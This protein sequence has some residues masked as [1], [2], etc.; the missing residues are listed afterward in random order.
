MSIGFYRLLFFLRYNFRC[1]IVVGVGIVLMEHRTKFIDFNCDLAQVS[2]I[3]EED[4]GLGLIDY[5]SSVN[6]ACGFHS[7]NPLAISNAIQHCRFKNKVVGAHIG[8]PDTISDVAS[9]SEDAI[10]AIVL[11][12]LGALDSFA[13]ANSLNIEHV[14]PHGYMYQLMSENLEFTTSVAKAI[15]KFNKWLLLYGPAGDVLEKAGAEAKLN[16]AREVVLNMPYNS[17]G[18]INF[19][20]TPI[21]DNELLISKLKRLIYHS[22]VEVEQGQFVKINFDTIHF[23]TNENVIDFLK[24]ASQIVSPR[25][26]NF[27]NAAAS[28]WVE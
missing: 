16:V 4:K 10:E 6:I 13:K 9:L 28:G 24:E 14:R 12:Q 19:S 15:R 20:A 7:G 8:L 2:D 17:D 5:V 27:N 21:S 1:K 23:S 11:Y 25:P 18:L 3:G 26:V 22:D